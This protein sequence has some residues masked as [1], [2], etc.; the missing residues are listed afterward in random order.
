MGEEPD[1][2]QIGFFVFLISSLILMVVAFYK[3]EYIQWY[4]NIVPIVGL[5][6]FIHP[7]VSY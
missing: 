1:R 4:M 5:I 3:P 6:Y 2:Y 7:W